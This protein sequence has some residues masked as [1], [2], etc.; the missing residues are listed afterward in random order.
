MAKAAKANQCKNIKDPK[1]R[2][3]CLAKAKKPNPGAEP[4]PTEPPWGPA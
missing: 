1:K 4:Y 3:A 2:K